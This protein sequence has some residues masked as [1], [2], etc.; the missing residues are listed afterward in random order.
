MC[1]N[2]G[3]KMLKKC[4]ISIIIPVYNAAGYLGQCLESIC[5]QQ[6]E[7][8]QIICIDDGST[9]DSFGILSEFAEKDHRIEVYRKPHT[10]AGEAR[11]TG[12]EHVKGNYVTFMDADDFAEAHTL[13]RAYEAIKASDAEICLIACDE[14]DDNEKIYI[15]SPLY[16]RTW[17][18][19]GYRPFSS[20]DIP[21]K[22]FNLGSATPWCKLFK[23]ELIFN[24]I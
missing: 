3:E 16:L 11:N 15:E 7:D 21:D 18:M 13:S 23:R 5:G 2:N 9:D 12:L 19:P 22:I 1:S 8:I 6:F 14:F 24:S 17:E 4:E 20:K 10:N